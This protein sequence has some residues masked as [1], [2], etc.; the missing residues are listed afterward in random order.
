MPLADQFHNYDKA[1]TLWGRETWEALFGDAALSS[2]ALADSVALLLKDILLATSGGRRSIEQL[3]NTAK[4]GIEWVWPFT[5]EHELSFTAFLYSIEG[6]I[7]GGHEP[8]DLLKQAIAVADAQFAG[9]HLPPAKSSALPIKAGPAETGQIEKSSGPPA[10][11]GSQSVSRAKRGKK[12]KRAASRKR[13][14]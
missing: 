6:L 1:N 12:S 10:R 13:S 4:E 7:V 8:C 3:R 2:Q 14:R 9:E 11:S 5:K